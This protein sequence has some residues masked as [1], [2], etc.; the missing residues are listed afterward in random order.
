MLRRIFASIARR[1]LGIVAA[2]GVGTLAPPASAFT[3]FR[4]EKAPTEQAREEPQTGYIQY[5]TR[6]ESEQTQ[7]K[8]AARYK[9]VG[10]M[11]DVDPRT[12]NRYYINHETK[13]WSWDAPRSF[14]KAGER[15]G[16]EVVGQQ[17]VA[18]WV[19]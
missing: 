17:G 6:S 7:A 4:A 10:W 11:E 3:L 5:Q 14:T 12:G 8:Q 18:M 13:Q 1:A 2:V 16:E 9:V 15:A 19:R